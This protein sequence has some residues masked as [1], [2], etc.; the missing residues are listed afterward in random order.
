MKSALLTIALAGVATAA[1]PA[2]GLVRRQLELWP[3]Q[4]DDVS[5][6]CSSALDKIR[7]AAPT[8]P[9]SLA[10]FSS[11]FYETASRTA[12]ATESDCAWVT[13][14]PEAERKA[15]MDWSDGSAKWMS[16]KEHYSFYTDVGLE[17]GTADLANMNE[18]FAC[19][20]EWTDLVDE[21]VNEKGWIPETI[22]LDIGD[23]MDSIEDDLSAAPGV[24]A[25]TYV[26]SAVLATFLGAAVLL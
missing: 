25:Q 9:P 10:E 5:S 15:W 8:I 17:C 11:S 19:S 13:E 14:M 26:I 6:G 16:D 18:D 12:T 24:G 2:G 4:G 20:T 23:L 21:L 22:D 3:G 1:T 7:G